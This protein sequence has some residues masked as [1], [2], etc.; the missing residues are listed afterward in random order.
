MKKFRI[1]GIG[2]FAEGQLGHMLH[3]TFGSFLQPLIL[4]DLSRWVLLEDSLLIGH[5]LFF[6]SK[7]FALSLK[8]CQHS[9]FP[10]KRNLKIHKFLIKNNL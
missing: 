9:L 6:Q 2:L 7:F 8:L 3:I 1:F 10:R 4:L 5:L